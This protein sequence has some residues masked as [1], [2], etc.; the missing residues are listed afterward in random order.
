MRQHTVCWLV[1]GIP[2]ANSA[3]PG[4][5]P[6][7]PATSFLIAES[8]FSHSVVLPDDTHLVNI[9]FLLETSCC[10]GLATALA[11]APDPRPPTCFNVVPCL[12]NLHRMQD[13]SRPVLHDCNASS[14]QSQT[15]TRLTLWHHGIWKYYQSASRVHANI[16]QNLTVCWY[17][18]EQCGTWPQYCF[19]HCGR[20]L[21][22][23]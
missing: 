7:L 2:A 5:L 16:K 13:S 9:F 22:Q 21:S 15:E 17:T 11:A 12:E 4:S 18:N 23:S 8:R 6:F 3:E 1:G 19:M 10:H 14:R 20:C